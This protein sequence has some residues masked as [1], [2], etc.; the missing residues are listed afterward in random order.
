MEGEREGKD[1]GGDWTSLK[2][3]GRNRHRGP[4]TRRRLARS[5]QRDHLDR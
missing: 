1:V 5:Q 4:Q 2:E 3:G